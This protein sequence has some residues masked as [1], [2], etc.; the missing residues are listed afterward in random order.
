MSNCRAYLRHDH[1]STTKQIRLSAKHWAI[2]EA[3]QEALAEALGVRRVS[4]PV[5]LRHILEAALVHGLCD[6]DEGY[7]YEAFEGTDLDEQ[8]PTP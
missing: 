4:K 2:I 3:K 8:Y 6:P 5:A 7:A 1:T